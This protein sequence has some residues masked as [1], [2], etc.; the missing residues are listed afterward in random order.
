LSWLYTNHKNN[1]L[2]ILKNSAENRL[3]RHK[4]ILNKFSENIINDLKIILNHHA[5][6]DLTQSKHDKSNIHL[7]HD[8]I[9]IAKFEKNYDQIRYIDEKGMETIRINY[10]DGH[11]QSVERELLQNKKDRYYFKDTFKLEKNQIFIS[12]MDLNI[13]NGTIEVP[14]KPMIRIG[15]PVFDNDGIKKGILI[16]NYLSETLLNSLED[17]TSS[18]SIMMLNRDGYFLKGMERDHEWGFMYQ[19]R[20]QITIDHRFPKSWNLI[21]RKDKGS[22]INKFGIFFFETVYPLKKS[23]ISSSGSSKAFKESREKINSDQYHW[24]LVLIVSKKDF[25]Q[26]IELFKRNVIVLNLTLCL[27]ISN[28]SA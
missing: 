10:N 5:L 11:P 8:L 17:K 19:N 16:V 15:C 7:V 26:K 25:E 21:K 4:E 22:F 9:Q 24:K 3:L 12:P 20:K 6:Q 27:I 2:S 23:I 28:Y 1:E 18:S 13:E 14:I